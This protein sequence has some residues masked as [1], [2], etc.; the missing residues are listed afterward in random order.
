MTVETPYFVVVT[1]TDTGVGKTRVAAA[2]GR[3][4]ASRGRRVVAIKPIE[5]GCDDASTLTEDGVL[6]AEATGQSAPR[7]ALLRLKT[8]VAP[9]I[10]ADL[11]SVDIDLDSLVIGLCEHAADAEIVLVEGAGGLCSPLSWNG[12]LVDVAYALDADALVVGADR[13]GVVNHTVLTMTTLLGCG[14]APLGV[15]LTAPERADASTHT[16]AE[17]LRRVLGDSVTGEPYE[18]VATAPRGD[19]RAAGASVDE[20]VRWIEDGLARRRERA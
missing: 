5:S 3:A 4:L 16:N 13:L 18:R 6:L 15:V 20:V 11:E 2:L 12:D 14:V 17:T 19:W 9:P 1:G 10:A 8:P 7:A